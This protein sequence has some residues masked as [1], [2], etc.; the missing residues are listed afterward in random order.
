MSIVGPSGSSKTELMFHMLQGNSFYPRFEKIYYFYKEFQ[1]LFREMRGS[2]ARIE[3]IKYSGLEITKNLSICLF[4]FD[5][6][7]EDIFNDKEFVK[8][9][10][11][12]RHR[13][14][15]VLYV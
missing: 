11:S 5:D 3:F 6:S 10:T 14:L 13:K 4:F 2:I 15:H 9:A 12:G 7:C 1:P 8:I